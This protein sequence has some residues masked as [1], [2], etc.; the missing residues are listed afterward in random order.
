M[1]NF[2]TKQLYVQYSSWFSKVQSKHDNITFIIT[3]F[4]VSEVSVIFAGLSG[5]LLMKVVF[6][7]PVEMKAV[8]IKLSW[9]RK[10]SSLS[11]HYK[12]LLNEVGSCPFFNHSQD[13]VSNFWS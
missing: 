1:I 5:T 10:L 12:A 7:L 8:I 11:L 4:P 13:T 9:G 6:I 3:M 2:S